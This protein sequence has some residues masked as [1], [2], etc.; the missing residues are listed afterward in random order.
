MR[1]LLRLTQSSLDVAPP[2]GRNPV[3]GGCPLPGRSPLAASLTETLTATSLP[4]AFLSTSKPGWPAQRE[5]VPA[6]GTR[7]LRPGQWTAPRR[8]PRNGHLRD[9]KGETKERTGQPCWT[10]PLEQEPRGKPSDVP[11]AAVHLARSNAGK[12]RAAPEAQKRPSGGPTCPPDDLAHD[13]LPQTGIPGSAR[14]CVR[15]LRGGSAPNLF[16]RLVRFGKPPLL[17]PV[18]HLAPPQLVRLADLAPQGLERGSPLGQL[19]PQFRVLVPV[20]RLVAVRVT[21]KVLLDASGVPTQRPPAPEHHRHPAA[22]GFR[23]TFLASCL[24][25]PPLRR[26]PASETSPSIDQSWHATSQ[27]LAQRIGQPATRA[28]VAMVCPAHWALRALD[29]RGEAERPEENHC[30][31]PATAPPCLSFRVASEDLTSLAGRNPGWST[32]PDSPDSA[33]SGRASALRP[34]PTRRSAPGWPG[35]CGPKQVPAAFQRM[36]AYT[37]EVREAKRWTLKP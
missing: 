27:V 36:A 23:S 33:N 6:A 3:A 29:L 15:R 35:G 11:P 21:A 4:P 2:P 34:G 5:T 12:R 28:W 22:K 14:P 7:S 26:E 1:A 37:N 9:P 18:Q 30:P 8:N 19:R 17:E 20:S 10:P 16:R 25:D 31:L 24:G 13:R 32:V